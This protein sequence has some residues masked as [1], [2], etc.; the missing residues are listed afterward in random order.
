M[1]DLVIRNANLVDGTGAPCRIADIGIDG[2]VI[3][4]VGSGVEAGKREIDAKGLLVTPGFVPPVLFLVGH[5]PLTP[6]LCNS[7][8]EHVAARYLVI[9]K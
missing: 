3:K 7:H 1:H 4:A 2:S 6:I 8:T 5:R 9:S